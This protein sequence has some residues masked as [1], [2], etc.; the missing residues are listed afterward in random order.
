MIE[1]RNVSKY[2]TANGITNMG[3]HDISVT[4]NTNEIVAITGESGSGKS[5]LLNV[6]AQVDGFDEGEM[7]YKGNEMSYF[8]VSDMDNFR[9][10]KVGF[11]FQNYNII[12]SYTVLENVMVPLLIQGVRRKEAK[13]KAL[14]LIEEVGL[15]GKERNRGTK[16]SGGEKQ[17]VV[18]ARALASDCEILA[19]DEPTGNL[20]SQ[21]GKEIID[22]ICRVAKDKLVLIVTHNYAEIE[23]VATRQLRLSDGELVDDTVYDKKPDDENKEIDLDYQ[24]MR[25]AA[26]A[27]IAADNLVFTPNKTLLTGV[28]YLVIA[29]VFLLCCHLFFSLAL[30]TSSSYGNT[31]ETRLVIYDLNYNELDLGKIKKLSS[32]VTVNGFYEDVGFSISQKNESR[33]MLSDFYEVYIC[34]HITDYKVLGGRTPQED[35]EVFIIFPGEYKNYSNA[36]AAL[37]KEFYL[38]PFSSTN[39]F[40]IDIKVCGY[41]KSDSV[42]RI[43]LLTSSNVSNEV[44]LISSTFTASYVADSQTAELKVVYMED[45]KGYFKIEAPLS[46]ENT[47]WTYKVSFFDIYDFGDIPITYSNKYTQPTLIV[48]CNLDLSS[49]PYQVSIY[50]QNAKWLMP[51]IR[52][53][54]YNVDHPATQSNDKGITSAMLLNILYMIAVGAVMVFVFFISYVLLSRINSTKKSDY[55]ILRTLG[56]TK[57][58]MA[59]IVRLEVLAI[60]LVTSIISGILVNILFAVRAFGY[61]FGAV[62]LSTNIYFVLVMVLFSLATSRRFNKRLYKFSVI[63]SIK[64]DE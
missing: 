34:N 12:D 20:D 41:G 61:T 51:A 3:L 45:S 6:I 35:G 62:A 9:R 38:T 42:E 31:L 33:S 39:K 36:K 53:M 49:H 43:F 55:E 58:E 22:L 21:T 32:H 1:L 23:N 14:Q 63:K 26:K 4:L 11:I 47:V 60:T 27:R 46:Y 56:V 44:N 37:N 16:L 48:P 19:C 57:R 30:P 54:G 40:N 25:F 10:S 15:S 52:N 17:R 8:S 2:Y 13:A 29:F 5:T 59:S 7:Y 50:E 18:I 24:P 64:E 28:V